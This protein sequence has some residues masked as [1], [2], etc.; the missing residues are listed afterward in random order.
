MVNQAR[1]IVH[2]IELPLICDADNGYGN[3]IDVVRTDVRSGEGLV[4]VN[5]VEGGKTHYYA[6]DRTAKG[7]MRCK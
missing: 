2:A 1:N 6:E 5:M 7:V 4:L 3:P